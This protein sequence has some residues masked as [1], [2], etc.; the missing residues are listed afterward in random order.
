MNLTI[1]F[2]ATLKERV[3]AT[4]L[5]IVIPEPATVKSL[6]VTLVKEHPTLD[7]ALETIIVAVNQEFAGPDQT[8]ITD[9]EIVLF[10][11]VS[12]G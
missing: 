9:D 4:Q 11:P 8:L 1:R 10:P 6:L 12:G 2:F 7:P 5:D 3:G